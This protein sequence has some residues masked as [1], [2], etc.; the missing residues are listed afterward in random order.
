[1]EDFTEEVSDAISRADVI[2]YLFSVAYPISVQNKF[3]YPQCYQA[4]KFYRD[5]SYRKFC[6]YY[7]R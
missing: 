3:F 5:V 4:A 7:G 6:G 1:M 2:V